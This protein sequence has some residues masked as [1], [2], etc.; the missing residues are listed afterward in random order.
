MP[1]PSAPAEAPETFPNAPDPLADFLPWAKRL[2]DEWSVFR[3]TVEAGSI[4]MWEHGH[5]RT[6]EWR[7]VLE[8]RIAECEALIRKWER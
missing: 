2:H 7:D 5:E 8:A 1:E 6:Q 3:R 4:R